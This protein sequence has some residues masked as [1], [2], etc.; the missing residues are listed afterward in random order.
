MRQVQSKQK[1]RNANL[2]WQILVI[3]IPLILVAIQWLTYELVTDELIY[4]VPQIAEISAFETTWLYAYLHLFSF[5]PVFLLS[6]DKRVQYSSSWRYLMPA[7]AIV[8]ALF[9]AWDVVFTEM[10][11][12]NFN[13]SYFLGIRFLSLP[14]EEWAFFFTIPFCCVFVYKCLNYYI[15]KDL[16][17]PYE[18][19]ISQVLIALSFLG[20]ILFWDKIYTST[21]F[22]LTGG[23][24]LYHYLFLPGYYRARFYFS[25]LVILLPF[26]IV[27]GV[28]TGGYTAE[29]IVLYNPAEFLNI[30]IG[31]VPIEDGIYGF[32]LVMGVVTLWEKFRTIIKQ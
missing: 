9:I 23:F 22:F 3:T 5:V 4:E 21:T 7:I 19:R 14:L 25:Y 11:V 6:F 24:I 8:G 27:D 18:Q 12:W 32:L 31:S 15:A 13:E 28:L 1:A 16:L 10:N 30:R 29:P 20:G 17:A 26:L 2:F